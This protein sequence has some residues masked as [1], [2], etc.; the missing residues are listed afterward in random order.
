[1]EER[2]DAVA[3]RINRDVIKRYF[4]GKKQTLPIILMI[5]GLCT[6]AAVIGIFLLIGGLVWFLYNKFSADL[7]GESEVDRAVQYEIN[8]AK[9]RALRK[10]N[11]LDEQVQDVPPVVVSGRGTEPESTSI[12]KNL[13]LLGK[14]LKVFKIK[15]LKKKDDI[16]DD[17]VYMVR[18]GS[19]NRF[20]CS[21]LSI[22]VFLFGESQL[23]IYYCDIDLCTGF[24]YR[25]GSHEYFYSDINAISFI[26]EK[27]KVYN[28]K[29]KKYQRVL[30]ESVKIFASGC[31]HTASL[32]ADED[33]SVIE[34]EFTGM[35]NL[36]RER[37]N[38]R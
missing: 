31:H 32:A 36:I 3:H 21:L 18:I 9:A 20:R 38:M 22:S 8:R 33:R 12:R 6:V 5:V 24:V 15:V 28:F 19:D 34:Q 37:K 11:L 10:L 30:F 35:R 2:K 26:Q 25:E 7:S 4:E 27:E 14:L 17:P 29:K 13:S 16:E 23:F 1:M